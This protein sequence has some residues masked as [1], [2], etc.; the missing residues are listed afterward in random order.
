MWVKRLTSPWNTSFAK[1]GRNVDVV[2]VPWQTAASVQVFGKQ[3]REQGKRAIIFGSDAAYSGDFTIPGSYVSA[4]APDVRGISGNAAFIAGYGTPFVSIF[5]P[6][7]Y[8][9]TQAAIL[10]VRKACADGRA[11]RAEVRQQL[12]ETR[13]PRT[14]MGG[15]LQFTARGDR[16]GATFSIFRLGAGGKK[17][18]VGRG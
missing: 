2:F 5:G 6:P 8:V 7:A 17:T 14:V 12:R 13:I 4:F 18:L 9:A 1:I 10:A 3:L 15:G 11:T 16:K